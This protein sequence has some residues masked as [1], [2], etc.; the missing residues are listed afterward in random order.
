MLEE[1][2]MRASIKEEFDG[3]FTCCILQIS[4][5]FSVM[6]VDLYVYLKKINF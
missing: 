5:V 4:L 3:G 1:K 6:V 2:A